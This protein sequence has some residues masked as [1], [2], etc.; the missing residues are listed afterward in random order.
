MYSPMVQY[1]S[2]RCAAP[3]MVGVMPHVH[4]AQH[5]MSYGVPRQPPLSRGTPAQPRTEVIRSPTPAHRV[6]R[7]FRPTEIA[8]QHM[9][10]PQFVHRE[11]RP[12]ELQ[13]TP[14]MVHREEFR[15][16]DI[17][18]TPAL[19]HREVRS[20]EVMRTPAVQHREVVRTPAL[21]HRE[22][23]R[24]PAVEHREVVRTP[25]LQHRE[26]VR[27]PALEHREVMRTPNVQ[28]REVR[29]SADVQ[30]IV[31]AMAS[32]ALPCRSVRP[33][34]ALPTPALSS[35]YP[36]HQTPS[37]VPVASVSSAMRQ[38]SG[39]PPPALARTGA[40]LVDTAPAKVSQQPAPV[41]PGQ[42][43]RWMV[44]P[45]PCQPSPPPNPAGAG[46]GYPVMTEGQAAVERIR[47]AVDFLPHTPPNALL[48]WLKYVLS[49]QMEPG[50][51]RP[52]GGKYWD[53]RRVQTSLRRLLE[54]VQEWVEK[55]QERL[56]RQGATCVDT[57]DLAGEVLC[58]I[59]QATPGQGLGTLDPD[60]IKMTEQEFITGVQLLGAWPPELTP[61]DRQEVFAALLVPTQRAIR[62][63]KEGRQGMPK[64]LDRRRLADG[65]AGVPYVL[66]DFPVPLHLLKGTGSSVKA[67]EV[68][69]DLAFRFGS[70]SGVD[71][72][73]DFYLS[74]LVSME[75]IQIALPDLVEIR[76]LEEA[77]E[78]VLRTA[79]RCFTA[80]EWQ[81]YV[82]SVRGEQQAR[83][84]EASPEAQQEARTADA[85][86]AGA[87]PLGDGQKHFLED[88]DVRR[89]V[90]WSTTGARKR[91]HQAD[92]GA[93][94]QVDKPSFLTEEAPEPGDEGVR[95]ISLDWHNECL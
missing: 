10:Q 77:V 12:A 6:V 89:V 41:A 48:D 84:E 66:P 61:G 5:P 82:Y 35:S 4:I 45:T 34:E 1:R 49:G 27:T 79:S 93:G 50:E 24:T 37:Q 33:S 3:E 22:V 39:T 81:K 75:E 2:V 94:K 52:D 88:L 15:H 9:A 91:S 46:G 23:V 90:D 57:V 87:A 56:M 78:L 25:A 63:L 40:A 29:V 74:G 36:V 32:P 16:V 54:S 80:A 62:Q 71:H 18:S 53:K 65:L 31:Q 69:K 43:L 86:L 38:V 51:P 20:T 58:G 11:Y 73:K 42:Q 19:V 7:Q 67:S 95:L 72:V 30:R 70:D 44:T 21:Q 85:G 60:K 47:T 55:R 26:V 68:A 13:P 14:A 76:K 64:V 92:E 59:W 8:Q 17:P 83:E 28:H